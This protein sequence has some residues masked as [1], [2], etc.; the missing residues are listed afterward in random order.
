MKK[1]T[2][3]LLG[4]CFLLTAAAQAFDHKHTAWNRLL[5]ENVYWNSSGVASTVDYQSL[6]KRQ[7]ELDQYLAGLSAVTEEDYNDWQKQQQLAFLINA[8]NAFTIKL[9]LGKYP[10]LESIKDL[11]SLFTSPWKKRFFSLLGKERH[12]D[13]IEHDMIRQPGVFGDPR[14]HAAVVCASIGC[15]GI[16]D[17]AFVAKKIDGQL[18]DSMRRFLSDRARNRYNP[19]T[20]ELEISKIFDW[21]GD[22]FI[23][24]RGHP[25]VSAFLSD[26]AELLTDD[27]A[28]QLRI[29]AGD[30][31]LD[32]LDYDWD[33]NDYRP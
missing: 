16:R 6:A 11:G 22:D 7:A 13:E 10:D 18:E 9:I 27:K 19:A 8:Y 20:D 28:L 5:R 12:L 31:P 29:K 15:P 32:Y 21:Y 23:G 25:S 24:F 30:T 14:I 4:C 1:I 17:E 2:F 3:L 33:L 26:Y